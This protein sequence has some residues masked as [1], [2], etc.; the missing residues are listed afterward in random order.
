MGFYIHFPTALG[1]LIFFGYSL[2]CVLVYIFLYVW[3]APRFCLVL[4]AQAHH[5]HPSS[6][7]HSVSQ[8]QSLWPSCCTPQGSVRVF[9]AALAGTPEYDSK[10]L[11]H[12]AKLLTERT[13]FICRESSATCDPNT[14]SE[15]HRDPSIQ[16]PLHHKS[17][18]GPSSAISVTY[19]VSDILP[20]ILPFQAYCSW[21]LCLACSNVTFKRF[22]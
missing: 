11:K 5:G 19:A 2:N 21:I 7:L 13:Q 14:D 15:V 6:L 18:S 12:F 1:R 17:P 9:P 10:G 16:H 3:P 4:A 8:T 22:P 20:E